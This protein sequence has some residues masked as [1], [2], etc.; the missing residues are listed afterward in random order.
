MPSC[1]SARP[2]QPALRPELGVADL[3]QHRVV[4]TLA[5]GHAH[6]E[7]D[8]LRDLAHDPLDPTELVEVGSRQIGA[9]GLVPA[10]VDGKTARHEC[11][12]RV[13]RYD[14]EGLGVPVRPHIRD[15]RV[16]AFAERR[17]GWA[18]AA[19]ATQ[20]PVAVGEMENRRLAQPALDRDVGN[21]RSR[22]LASR[23]PIADLGACMPTL[24]KIYRALPRDCQATS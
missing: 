21:S 9:R 8:A 13:G 11:L 15:D 16:C 7:R 10:V 23:H 5:R 4:D 20:R 24:G 19:L 2:G 12:G 17:H 1:D 18:P 6:A 22:K 3:V 14:V